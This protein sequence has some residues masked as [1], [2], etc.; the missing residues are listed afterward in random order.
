MS[1][2]QF[3]RHRTQLKLSVRCGK[4]KMWAMDK[5]FELRIPDFKSSQRLILF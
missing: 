2:L 4:F 3:V 1:S 5:S